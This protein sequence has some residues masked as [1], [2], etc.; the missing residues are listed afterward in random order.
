MSNAISFSQLALANPLLTALQ[1]AGY[2]NP[3]PIQAEAIPVLLEGSDL[4]GQAQ[5]GTG[6]TAA[7]ALPLLNRL[8][9]K[10]RPPQILVLTPTRELAIQVSESFQTYARHLK[11]VHVVPIYGGQGYSTQ[12]QELK[13]GVHVV[14]GTPGR[15]LDHLRR[16]SLKID[17]LSAVVLDEADEMLRMGFIE[18]VEEI[19]SN[20]P[21]HCHMAM[22]SATMPTPIK[23]IAKRYLKDPRE[24][25]IVSQTTTVESVEQ[26]HIFLK[27]HQKL[28][29]LAQLLAVED[30]DGAIVFVR[31][32]SSTVTVA[33][34][35]EAQGFAAS[36][37]NGDMT[38]ALREKTIQRLKEKK[39][40]IVV[41]TDVAARGLDLERLSLVVNYDIPYET[42]SYV[43]RIGRTGR[44]GRAGKAIL[45]VNPSEKRL[46]RAIEQATRQKIEKFV[47]PTSEELREKRLARLSER[48][49]QTMAEQP[50]S[51]YDQHVE[52]LKD[53]LD[54]STEEL[55][56]ALLYLVQKD[57][58]LEVKN[59]KPLGL[60]ERPPRV[61]NAKGKP[62]ETRGQ[63]IREPKRMKRRSA[64]V[65]TKFELYRLEVGKRHQVQVG[66]I[67]GAIANEADIESQ[68][69]G[70]IKLYEEYSTVELPEGM[71]KS[72]F[73]H[74]KKVYV[75]QR[76]LNLKL[77]NR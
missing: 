18:D 10:K 45:F 30:Y 31:T 15:L 17:S 14:V 59:L 9:L 3:T 28:E 42:E 19:L 77:W 23:R 8:D 33:E 6:K 7:F 41:A 58:P 29:A 51:T 34:K 71:P 11:G 53:A 20:A 48:L 2:E 21:K 39:S 37:L 55:A 75:R 26:R 54:L 70:H 64:A 49:A 32:K 22:F 69:I 16:G 65:D 52:T 24:V 38:Q 73:H 36:A 74:L 46:L 13:R 40:D 35:L 50:T 76:Q 4:L 12:L 47:L 1:E 57:H 61:I 67:V 44:A 66:D 43:H 27:D 25:K 63:V 60:P 72:I 68:Y 56:A 5:T 62:R